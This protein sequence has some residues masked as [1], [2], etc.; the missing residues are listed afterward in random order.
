MAQPVLLRE[1]GFKAV[2]EIWAPRAEIAPRGWLDAARYRA[3]P[4]SLALS[5]NS[6]PAVCGG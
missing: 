4:A 5:G 6:N 3:R 2:W 1:S